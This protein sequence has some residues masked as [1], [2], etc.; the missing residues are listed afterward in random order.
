MLPFLY[1]VRWVG[2][3]KK[4]ITVKPSCHGT[5]PTI[6]RLSFVEQI[7]TGIA[8]AS[9]NLVRHRKCR[10]DRGLTTGHHRVFN[11]NDQPPV[12][13]GDP[14][15]KSDWGKALPKYL[16]LRKLIHVTNKLLPASCL[17]LMPK[18]VRVFLARAR[19]SASG[20][21]GL[22]AQRSENYIRILTRCRYR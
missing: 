4:T 12:I 6:G 7:H 13:A 16:F 22:T 17:F 14:Y 1:H 5:H 19:C 20:G 3:D 8:T 11:G 15:P 18:R 21:I 2:G 9:S 10:S